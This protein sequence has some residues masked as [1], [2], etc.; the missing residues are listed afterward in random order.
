MSL[1][2]AE[3]LKVRTA[4]WTTVLLAVALLGITVLGAASTL[5]SAE[6]SQPFLPPSVVADV[7]DVGAFAL[8][9]ALLL[10]ILIVTW[11]YRHGTITQ[12][13]LAAPRRA[14]VVAAKLA[15]ALLLGLV[16]VAA[17]VAI[18][19]VMGKLW[20]GAEFA[21]E[22]EHWEQIARILGA[23]ALWTFLGAGLGATLQTQV[24]ALVS[25]LIWFL[26]VEPILGGLRP[27]IAAYLPGNALNAF[28]T[29]GGEHLSQGG[30]AAV[31]AAYALAAVALGTGAVLRRDV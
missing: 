22:G 19:L 9:F 30:A 20:L 12:T 11:D 10:G 27:G 26:V 31:A 28:V 6:D 8:V 24:G 29:G 16:F 2:A 15:A 1:F 4:P 25:A 14:E 13:F 17:A 23:A 21:I 18:A 3:L 5:A 7:I